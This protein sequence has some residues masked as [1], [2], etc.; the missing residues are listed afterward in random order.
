MRMGR[1]ISIGLLLISIQPILAQG[2]NEAV[3]NEV[4]DRLLESI[5]EQNGEGADYTNLVEWLDEYFYHPLN[6][7]TATKEDLEKLVIIDEPQILELE[8]YIKIHGPLLSIYEL[9]LV[10]GWDKES[11][12]LLLPF[13]K[14]I[15]AL[16]EKK[17]TFVNY[18]QYGKHELLFRYQQIFEPQSGFIKDPLGNSNYLGS[19]QQLY[20]RYK[21]SH[22]DKYSVGVTAKKDRGEEFFQ[23]TNA[24]GFDFYSAHLFFRNI[25]KFK[26]IALGDYQVQIGQ[27]LNF[28]KGFG[29]RKSAFS[30]SIMRNARGVGA[31]T[32]ANSN[33]YLRGGAFEVELWK[34]KLT[35]FFSYDLKDAAID[36]TLSQEVITSIS[37]TGLHRTDNEV[38]KRERFTEMVIGNYLQYKHSFFTVGGGIY[39]TRYSLDFQQGSQLYDHYDYTGNYQL[40][41]GFDYKMRL[42]NVFLFGELGFDKDLNYA[43]IQGLETS[44]GGFHFSMSYRD[45][46]KGYNNYHSNAFGENSLAKNERGF[47][48]GVSGSLFSKFSFNSYFD[49]YQFPWLRYNVDAPSWGFDGITQL[50][51][52]PSYNADIYVRYKLS[53]KAQNS[54]TNDMYTEPQVTVMQ[55]NIRLH[56]VFKVLPSVSLKSRVEAVFIARPDAGFRW[57]FLAYQDVNWQ[58]KKLPLTASA[59]FAI[60]RTDDFDT[61]LYAYENDLLYNFSVPFYYYKGLRWYLNVSYK[62]VKGFSI[63][64]RLSQFIYPE[65]TTIGSG[66]D[67][68]NGITKTEIKIQARY[69]FGNI[70]KQKEVKTDIEDPN[71]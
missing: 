49:V 20:L 34:L 40:N 17:R 23:G 2:S 21:Y 18:L 5:A 59:R 64:L 16:E 25:G 42:G 1:Y 12:F 53:Q 66:N 37:N 28:W 10:K 71:D 24:R 33:N 29:F 56:A 54:L 4:I 15:P 39:Y 52:T 35:S 30:T 65:E 6:I 11:I 32:S 14:V 48:L 9:Q 57:G 55:H 47:Y 67:L 27:G 51:Y 50:N 26:S 31:Y 63:S 45:Y 43:L 13:I 22:T 3:K 38:S 69:R 70:R 8:R 58:P 62:P 41:G 44:A 60:F 68:I 61:R 36:S 7:N 19:P 46:S